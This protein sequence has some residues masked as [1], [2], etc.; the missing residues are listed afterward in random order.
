MKELNED[1]DWWMIYQLIRIT[2]RIYNPILIEYLEIETKGD[3]N[4]CF[5]IMQPNGIDLAIGIN[6]D[7]V[8]RI[9]IELTN[10]KLLTIPE[11][12][13]LALLMEYE[14]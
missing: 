14:L 2:Y 11:E 4:P 6:D 8:C 12:V 5:V 3:R 10:K 13:L 7:E 1:H 9:P